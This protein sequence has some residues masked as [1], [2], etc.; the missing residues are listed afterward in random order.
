[1]NSTVSS[2]ATMDQAIMT[3]VAQGRQPDNDMLDQRDVLLDKLGGMVN[4]SITKQ[5][6]G[7]VTLKVGSF[8]LLA[9]GTATSV[10]NVS[11][12][13]NDP[14]P[15]Q[16]NLTSGKLAGLVDF[17]KQ[18]TAYQS[19]LDTIAGSLITKVN[20]LQTGGYDLNGAATTGTPFFTG[21]NASNIDINAAL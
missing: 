4:L 10:A 7:S 18:V 21:T 6:D 5:T 20:A 9:A 11:S 12:F 16:P 15:S 19:Q 17:G 8:T 1:L 3:S 14:I 13:G 2:I